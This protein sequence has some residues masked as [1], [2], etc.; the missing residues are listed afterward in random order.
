MEYVHYLS[1]PNKKYQ[2]PFTGERKHVAMGG[3]RHRKVLTP[4]FFFNNSP[5]VNKHTRTHT[6]SVILKPH[7]KISMRDWKK[8]KQLDSCHS[9]GCMDIG[10][11]RESVDFMLDTLSHSF[12]LGIKVSLS[13]YCYLFTSLYSSN[14]CCTLLFF[15]QQHSLLFSR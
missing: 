4:T 5:P 1:I 15:C 12:N 3:Q 14:S 8:S 10:A 9:Q 2:L 11:L 13:V 6:I 7:I